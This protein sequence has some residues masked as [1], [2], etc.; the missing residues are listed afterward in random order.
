MAEKMPPDVDGSTVVNPVIEVSKMASNAEPDEKASESSEN[1]QYAIG[2]DKKM[3]FTDYFRVFGYSTIPEKLVMAAAFLAAVGAGVTMPLMNVVFGRLVGN[4]S[5]FNPSNGASASSFESGVNKNAQPISV[6]DALPP[7]QTATAITATAN[8]LQVGVSEKLGT[9]I[10]SITLIIAA[11]V[12]SFTHSWALTLVTSSSLLF[13]MIIYSILVPQSIKAQRQVL[14]AE[15]KA[16]AIASEA[17]T[18]IRMIVACGAE[19]RMSKKYSGWIEE[20][21]RRGMK[22][23]PILGIQFAPIFFSVYATFGL[24]FWFGTVKLYLKGHIDNVGTVVIVIMSVMLI[25]FSLGQTAAPMIAISNAASAATDY[26]AVID[27]PSPKTEGLKE[28]DVSPNGDIVFKSV[29][30]AYPSRAYVKILDNLDLTFE[31]GK[32]TAICGASGSG[33]STITGLIERW[34]SLHENYTNLPPPTY[35]PGN[36]KV[37]A[38]LKAKEDEA[39]VEEKKPPV[40]LSGTV[41]ID[42]HS[43][44]DLDLKW[45]RSQIGLVQQEPFIFNDTIRKN[46][47]YGLIGTQWEDADDEVKRQLVESACEEA[48]AAEYITKLPL[49]YQTQVGD[50]GIKLS[51][52]QRQ[53][54]AIARAIIKKPTILILD[55]ATSAID[56]RSEQIVQAALDRASTGRTTITIAHRLST[57]KKA[58]KIVVLQKGRVIEQGSHESLLENENGA[59]WALVNAQKLSLGEGFADESDLVEPLARQASTAT[60]AVQEAEIETPYENKGLIRSFGLLLYE[61]KSQFPMYFVMLGACMTAGAGFPVQ[62]FLFAQLISVFQYTGTQLKDSASHW[63]L[64][65]F[66][67]AICVGCAYFILGWSSNTISV[68]IACTYRQQYFESILAKRIRFFDA[69]ENSSGTLTGRVSNDPTQLQQLLGLNMALV[70]IAIFNV[71]GCVILAYY[72][73]WKLTLLTFFVS[74]PIILSAGYFRVRYELMFERMNQEV[75]E[76]SSQFASE[77]MGAVRTVAALTLEDMI[78]TRYQVLLDK[79][80]IKAFKKARMS[81]FVFAL[82]DS[83][84]M[85]CMALTFWYGGRLIARGEY[86]PLSFFVVY[87]GV[88]QGSEGAGNWLSFGPNMAQAAAAANRILALRKRDGTGSSGTGSK[89]IML[90]D[91]EGGVSIELRDLWFKYPTRDIPIFTGLNITIEKGQFAALVGSSGSGKSSIISLLER[92]YDPQQGRILFNNTNIAD[93]DIGHYRN[94]LSLVAQE[95]TL[96]QGTIRENILLGVE[97][98]T[99]TD[100]RLHQVCRDSEIHNFISSLPE[101]YNTDVGSKGVALS[102]GQKQRIAIAR[103]LIRDPSVLLLDEA[104]S[105][106]DSESERLVQQ[107]FE[108][109]GQGRTMVVV[110]HRLATVQNADVIFVLGEGKVLEKGDHGALLR[111]KGVYYQMC[112][113]QALDR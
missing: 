6:L 47:E 41:S 73:G 79:Q 109:A 53:R 28:P 66:I 51:G 108:R 94:S 90:N 45:W 59:Y 92:F 48:F 21:R 50:A 46:V 80:V 3:K 14:H 76:E 36:Q 43:L 19:E 4:F 67:L 8:T 40:E 15:E 77:A 32:R 22:L 62:A 103:A 61:Q 39:V 58:D 38:A 104:T 72:F 71:L 84:A 102:G 17:L 98:S 99:I 93:M 112:Q 29:T 107:A 27:A 78:L 111:R 16:S 100:E 30:F 89:D 82:S 2:S 57:I 85:L 106:L 87:I 70:Y 60:L 64:M 42:G 97:E 74:M 91:T 96:F 13:I 18:A 65:F 11:V 63:S 24:A 83:V 12:V 35:I 31:A 9:F 69:D 5:S 1:D 110:A 20:C 81:S 49:G 33:K 54:L 68:H 113:S 56:V 25:V 88:V 101:G 10:Q 37:A 95:P 55:E 23:G 105:S 34:Y 52:G 75:F 26:F 44:E 7:G 86:T